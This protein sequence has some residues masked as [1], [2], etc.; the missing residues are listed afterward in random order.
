MTHRIYAVSSAWTGTKGG[1]NIFNRFL[2]EALARV[3]D[4]DVEI[5]AVIASEATLPTG[6]GSNLRFESYGANPKSLADTV[7]AGL[8]K[9][10]AKPQSTR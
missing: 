4:Q 2:V 3:V 8:M 1:I 10:G 9:V 6:V 5:H 7:K